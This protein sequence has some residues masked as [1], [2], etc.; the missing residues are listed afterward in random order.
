VRRTFPFLALVV[1]S[2]CGGPKR[3]VI[4]A[5]A[6][7]SLELPTADPDQLRAQCARRC[8]P[9]LRADETL[10]RCHWTTLDIGLHRRFEDVDQ[11][12]VVCEFE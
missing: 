5:R 11:R 7:A 1:L 2:A 6:T 10:D 4:V 8:A 12:A 9:L 3:V